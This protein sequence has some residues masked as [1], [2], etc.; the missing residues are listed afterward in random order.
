MAVWGKG[1]AEGRRL[2][3]ANRWVNDVGFTVIKGSNQIQLRAERG[4]KDK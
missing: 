1:K 2:M 4:D 3:V